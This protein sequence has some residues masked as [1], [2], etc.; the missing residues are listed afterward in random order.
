LRTIVSSDRCGAI[1]LHLQFLQVRKTEVVKAK[2]PNGFPS[3]RP[4][5]SRSRKSVLE[6]ATGV[7][8]GK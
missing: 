5:D 4:A 7:V 2:S 3:L 6:I 8:A 1:P